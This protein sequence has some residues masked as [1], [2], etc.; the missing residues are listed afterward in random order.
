MG[1]RRCDIGLM[2]SH[3]EVDDSTTGYGR[4]GIGVMSIVLG[5]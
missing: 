1:Y 2:R 5:I 4:C 3:E